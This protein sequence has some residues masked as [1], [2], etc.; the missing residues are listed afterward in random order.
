MDNYSVLM[1]VYKKDNPLFLQM[2]ID[3]MLMQSYLTDDF[4]I[5]CDGFLTDK[6]YEVLNMYKAYSVINIIQL[7]KNVGLGA[8]L[9]EGLKYCKNEL[10]ARMDSDD[11]SHPDR[12]RFQIEEFKKNPNL[13]LVGTFIEEFSDEPSQIIGYKKVPCTEVEIYQFAKRRNPFN[14]PTVMYKR[15]FILDNGGYSDL[16]KGQDF[17]LFN[18]LVSKH[19]CCKNIAKYL[20]K[21]RR[22]R[23]FIIRRKSWDSAKTNIIIIYKSFRRHYSSIIDLIYTI[24]TQIS[25]LVLP[26]KFVDTIYKKKYRRKHIKN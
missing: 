5:V 16:R 10:V 17:E 8:A 3:S 23:D 14:H 15:S 26:V 21:F 24:V 6:L 9:N 2:S 12:C 19:M 1:S 25:L 7:E 11:I 18:R 20:L 22:D 4:V 13:K